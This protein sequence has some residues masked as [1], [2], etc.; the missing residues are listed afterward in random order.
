MNEPPLV[1]DRRQELCQVNRRAYYRAMGQ[2]P[3]GRRGAG[4]KKGS[5]WPS[6]EET[7]VPSCPSVGCSN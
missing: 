3:A 4:H 5:R 7:D 2:C 6:L 1:I